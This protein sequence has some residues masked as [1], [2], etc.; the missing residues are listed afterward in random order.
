MNCNEL[1]QTEKD[2]NGQQQSTRTAMNCNNMA[3]NHV[4]TLF[5]RQAVDTEIYYLTESTDDAD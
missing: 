2:C 4:H 3:I 5:S 1:W